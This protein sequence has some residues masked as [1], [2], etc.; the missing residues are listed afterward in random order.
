MS[1][2]ASALDLALSSEMGDNLVIPEG[3][4]P[5]LFPDFSDISVQCN[6][7]V[8]SITNTDDRI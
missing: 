5:F 7:I 3:H 6:E 4:A 1:K 2:N 8:Q